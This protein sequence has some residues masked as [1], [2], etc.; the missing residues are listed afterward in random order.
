[1]VSNNS[2]EVETMNVHRT[3]ILQ[4]LNTSS[5]APIT[6][7]QGKGCYLYDENGKAY[8]DMLSGLWCCALGHSHPQ[9]VTAL[10]DQLDRLTHCHSSFRSLEIE[11]ANYQ[12]STVL[13]FYLDRVTWLNTGS[14]AVEFALKIA[15][16]ANGRG[17]IIVWE[18]G[19]YGATNLVLALSGP[20]M[21]S[22]CRPPIVRIPAP[23]CSY[24]PIQACYPD[25]DFECLDQILSQVNQGTAVLYEPVM[26]VGGVIVPPPGYGRR[27][28]EWA[29][30]LGALFI[31]EEVTT[32][33]GR[34]GRWF[35]FQHDDLHPDILVLGKALGNGL[36]VAAVVASAEVEARC[37]GK[38]RHVQSHQNDPWSG[39]VVAN[40]IEIIKD[41]RLVEHSASMGQLFLAKLNDL[42][43]QWPIVIEARGK[44]LMT[45]IELT[46]PQV[47]STL[48]AHLR[49]KGIIADHR[50]SSRYLRF[51]PPY[52]IQAE[53]VERVVE[54]IEEGLPL[55][56]T[57]VGRPE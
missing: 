23:H 28:Q 4:L 45:A 1:M 6:L 13:P 18:G 54:A 31:L 44:G 12:L 22:W 39:A 33:M 57:S 19:Y 27:V 36:P 9:F 35:G 30:R 53:E 21:D 3:S 5:T 16:I 43:V 25:C 14:E 29:R 24:C 17:K 52:V 34:T 7:T 41:E 20:D 55:C 47:A 49:A 56:K 15:L 2:S 37:T 32:G 40:L 11:V 48:Q 26:A 50:V 8:L 51:F 10:Q 46:E 38:L 42:I